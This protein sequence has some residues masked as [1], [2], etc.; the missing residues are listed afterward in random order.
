MVE[1]FDMHRRGLNSIIT[2][3]I[4]ANPSRYLDK[5]TWINV[6]HLS[7]YLLETETI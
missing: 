7:K 2:N 5:C 4:N 6:K 3:R 1:L